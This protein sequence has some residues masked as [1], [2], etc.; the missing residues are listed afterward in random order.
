MTDPLPPPDPLESPFG[1]RAGVR[2]PT[3]TTLFARGTPS[4]EAERLAD[5]IVA[6]RPGL[7]IVIALD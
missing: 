4:P 1:E 5:A 6:A 7:L 3:P 2:V